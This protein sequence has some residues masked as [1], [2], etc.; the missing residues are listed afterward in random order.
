M[1][2]APTQTPTITPTPTITRTQTPTPSIT[3]TPQSSSAATP[4]PTPTGISYANCVGEYFFSE[5]GNQKKLI[6]EF[7]VGT[8]LGVYGI[9]YNVLNN[10]KRFKIYNNSTL[11]TTQVL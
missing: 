7:Y 3:R 4:T 1:E 8:G 9:Q 5:T 11:L 6:F 10:P 2:Q